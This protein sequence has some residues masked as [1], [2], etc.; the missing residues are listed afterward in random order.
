MNF[1]KLLQ[2][3]LPG[4]PPTPDPTLLCYPPAN[5]LWFDSAEPTL[6]WQLA[7]SGQQVDPN[8]AINLHLCVF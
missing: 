7:H 6:A 4:W 3:F 8:R 1:D 2:H 5:M